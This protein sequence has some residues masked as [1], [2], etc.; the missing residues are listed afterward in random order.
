M[1]SV[2]NINEITKAMQMISTFRFKRAESRFSR[3]RS[4]LMEMEGIL[5]NLLASANDFSH[6]LF[7]Q[8]K[9]K[10][11]ALIVMTGDKGLCGSY[12]ANLLKETK[13]WAARNT[14]VDLF[15]IPVGKV[16][17]ETL[18]KRRYKLSLVY[19]E[20]AIADSGLSKKITEELKELFLKGIV[21]SVELLYTS[22]KVG[23][24]GQNKIQPFLPLNHLVQNKKDGRSAIEYI[25][26]PN[27]QEV[28][29]SLIQKFLEGKIYLSLLESLTSEHSARRMAMKQ[30]SENGEE[31]L[32]SLKLLKNKTR[33]AM[34]TRELSE[35]VGGASVLV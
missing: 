11:K 28:F 26:E 19:P 27:F 22:F 34:I 14:G 13:Y 24:A 20:K 1:K 9:Q 10:K 7:E 4:Y 3:I 25:Y 23:A 12:N 33:Q 17:A 21:D 30:A 6:P 2:E 32:D 18:K 35:I 15:V 5:A 16:G 31:V 8:R 29:I